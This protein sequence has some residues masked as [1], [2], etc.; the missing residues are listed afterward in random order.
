MPLKKKPENQ[1]GKQFRTDAERKRWER[2]HETP[3]QARSRLDKQSKLQSA[4]REGE[5][6]NEAAARLLAQKEY[7]STQRQSETEEQ[8]AV[9]LDRIR[10]HTQEMR[11]TETV[12]RLD[13]MRVH[14]QEMRDTETDEQHDNRLEQKVKLYHSSLIS[15]TAVNLA[16]SNTASEVTDDM[17][18]EFSNGSMTFVC[19]FCGSVFWETEKLLASTKSCLKFSLCCGQGK[20]VLPLFSYTS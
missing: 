3:E 15:K 10:V 11:D 20:V 5:S 1:G 4:I 12:V 7:Q 9:R 6:D 14:T 13:R 17:V 16:R 2:D 8:T 19:S 18:K